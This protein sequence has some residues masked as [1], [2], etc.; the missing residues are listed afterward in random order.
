VAEASTASASAV[1]SS[2]VES[3][4]ASDQSAESVESSQ[5]EPDA[6]YYF[7][8]GVLVSQDVRIEITDYK[9]VD[10]GAEGNELGDKPAIVFYYDCTNLT[11]NEDVSAMVAWIAMFTAIQ[12]NDPNVVNTLDTGW[13]TD[14]SISS[15]GLDTI[16]KDGTVSYYM[17]YELDDTE[18]PVVLEATRGV[19]GEELG[20]QTFDIANK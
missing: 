8:D 18:T 9:V 15:D 1:E 5:T 19:G 12:D 16:K 14:D 6:K 17:S 4:E 2:A 11:G 7:A 3:S 20:T 10:A 13:Y